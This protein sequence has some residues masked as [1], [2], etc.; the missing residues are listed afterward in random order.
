MI[1]PPFVVKEI[2]AAKYEILR[3][4]CNKCEIYEPFAETKSAKSAFLI[5]TA[6][7]QPRAEA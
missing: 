1:W 5:C 3:L 2:H 7:N 4:H 6:L